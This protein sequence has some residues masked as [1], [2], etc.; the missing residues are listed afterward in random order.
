MTFSINVRC[1]GTSACIL[2]PV[3][4]QFPDQPSNTLTSVWPCHRTRYV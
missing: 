2:C 3:W 1:M 4:L